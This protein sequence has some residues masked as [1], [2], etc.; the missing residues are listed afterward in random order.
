MESNVDRSKADH[1]YIFAALIATTTPNI[2]LGIFV[3]SH[4][5]RK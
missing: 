3:F 4:L 1:I 2:R 5:G